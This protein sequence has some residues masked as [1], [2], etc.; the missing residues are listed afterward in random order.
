MHCTK[1]LEM[2]EKLSYLVGLVLIHNYMEVKGY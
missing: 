1:L 2:M